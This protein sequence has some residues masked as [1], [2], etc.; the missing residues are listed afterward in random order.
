MQMKHLTK[1][2]LS[3]SLTSGLIQ[4]L[5]AN[6]I[7]SFPCPTTEMLKNATPIM[8]IPYA[9]DDKHMKLKTVSVAALEDKAQNIDWAIVMTHLPMSPD[10][11]T[12]DSI[13]ATLAHLTSVF[14]ASHHFQVLNHEYFDADENDSD[15]DPNNVPDDEKILEKGAFD[16]CVYRSTTPNLSVFA[17]YSASHGGESTMAKMHRLQKQ[18]RIA[19]MLLK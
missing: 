6:T 16:Y 18:V 4:P 11:H 3:L 10:E 1:L 17:I 15:Y 14:N 13:R 7:P 12:M 8:S 5:L 19:K 9:F 2:L